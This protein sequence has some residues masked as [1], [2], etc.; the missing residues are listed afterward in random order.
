[1]YGPA[2]P[3]ATYGGASF[4]TYDL[5]SDLSATASQRFVPTCS[6]VKPAR[7]LS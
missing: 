5:A 3:L 4:K 7:R 6:S 2:Y 1:M